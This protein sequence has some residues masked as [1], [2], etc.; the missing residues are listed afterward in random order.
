MRKRKDERLGWMDG[1][2]R[3]PGV[4]A[5]SCNCFVGRRGLVYLFRA[6]VVFLRCGASGGGNVAFALLGFRWEGGT[7][8]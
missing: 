2:R 5:F 8:L 3:C 1:L 7:T 4:V 6:V